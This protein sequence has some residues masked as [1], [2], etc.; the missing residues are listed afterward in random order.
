MAVGADPTA[1]ST[2]AASSVK[3]SQV[4]MALRGTASEAPTPR[5]SKLMNLE[6]DARRVPNSRAWR[7]P[8]DLDVHAQRVERQE[9]AR[10]LAEDLIS[11]IGIT[12]TDVSSL[13]TR[14]AHWT[15]SGFVSAKRR[16][17]P[18]TPFN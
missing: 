3:S 12:D 11:H 7:H 4:G 18:G 16:Q 6:M 17:A 15:A 13:R 10:T 14:L 5:R 2:A 9:I 8:S 1:S